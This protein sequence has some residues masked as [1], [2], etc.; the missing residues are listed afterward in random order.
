MSSF[1][2]VLILLSFVYALALGH[3]LQRVGGLLVAR[4]RVR[5]MLILRMAPFG[6]RVFLLSTIVEVA[7]AT[8]RTRPG[9]EMLLGDRSADDTGCL[10]ISQL[11]EQRRKRFASQE[12]RVSREDQNGP[13]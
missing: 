11:S 8:A 13:S 2:F 9:A 12:R 6:S 7:Y 1:D 5:F 4:E 3:V 10:L